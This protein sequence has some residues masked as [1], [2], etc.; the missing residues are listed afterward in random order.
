MVNHEMK[1]TQKIKVVV[2]DDHAIVRTGLV[3]LL[4]TDPRI[5]VIGEA[6][7]GESAVRESLRLKPDV[8]I[9]D[10]AMPGMDGATATAEIVSRLPSVKIMILTTFDTSDGIARAL[11]GGAS[12]ALMKSTANSEL[13]ETVI[14][15][16]A[17]ERV[18]APDIQ[19]LLVED[20]PAQAMTDRQRDILSAISLGL[21]NKDIARQ[22]NISADVV[23]EHVNVILAK[24]GAANRTEAVTIALKKHLLKI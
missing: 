11:A 12:G 4:D 15:I 23:K 20:P 17:G 13:L 14:R 1:T 8:V 22:F 24:L 21:T 5:E 2:A 6:E 3:A 19:R 16:A 10:L 7:D 18:I 9:M